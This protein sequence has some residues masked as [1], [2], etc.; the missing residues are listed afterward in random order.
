MDFAERTLQ[1]QIA[2]AILNSPP[3]TAVWQGAQLTF[4]AGFPNAGLI[5][6]IGAVVW[7]ISLC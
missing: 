5:S 1:R 2:L 7:I 3:P 6:L 4:F